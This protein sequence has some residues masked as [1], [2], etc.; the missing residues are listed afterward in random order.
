[1]PFPLIPIA[2]TAVAS[3]GVIATAGWTFSK[4][5]PVVKEASNMTKWLVIGGCVSSVAYVA[6]RVYV[7]E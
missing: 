4:A 3:S 2:V 1:M 6:Y 5:E 7:R